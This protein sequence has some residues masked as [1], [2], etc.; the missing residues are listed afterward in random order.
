MSRGKASRYLLSI[1]FVLSLNFL[2]VQFLPG[3]PLVHLLGEEAY[4][5]LQTRNPLALTE[6]RARYGL[7][8]PMVERYLTAMA[9]ILRF[10][11]GWSFQYGR[12]VSQVLFYRLKW[13]ML[14]LVPAVCLSAAFGLFLG[15]LTGRP[16][17]NPVDRVLT[18]LCLTIYA[19]PAYC[20]AFLL[21]LVFA[22]STDLLP[23]G[24]M[25]ASSQAGHASAGDVL[26][27][28]TLPLSVLVLHNTAYLAVIMR[29][30]VR[31]AFMEDYVVTAVS[32]GLKP[33][34]VMLRHVLLNALSPFVAAVA[35][36]FGF[37][38]AGALLVEVVFSWQGMGTLMYEAVLAR[39]Y[40]VLSG[41]FLIL[42]LAVIGANLMADLFSTFI[43][44][45]VRD[46]AA[47]A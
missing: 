13:T 17:K 19:A 45:R 33:R 24:G 12:P 42:A 35:I 4:V 32:K 40:P 25:T 11:L 26:R 38:A 47:S 9:D 7:N 22:F 37:I 36:N 28:L 21:L 2:I 14:L 5:H 30:A 39:D 15:C 46:D 3:D 6:L 1:V 29:G 20:L 23:L 16:G 41:C 34:A 18:P 43:D 8:R 10:R 27:H 44:P 31:Q